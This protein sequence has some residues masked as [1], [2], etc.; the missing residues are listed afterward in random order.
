[1]GALTVRRLVIGRSVVNTNINSDT[2]FYLTNASTHRCK[3]KILPKDHKDQVNKLASY[4]PCMQQQDAFYVHLLTQRGDIP[5]CLDDPLPAIM[6]LVQL[7]AEGLE[8][9]LNCCAAA[10]V[11]SVCSSTSCDSSGG[12]SGSH[13]SQAILSLRLLRSGCVAVVNDVTFPG[14]LLG[15][16][17]G[18]DVPAEQLAGYVVN[19][20]VLSGFSLPEKFPREII[21]GD[22]GSGRRGA[23]LIVQWEPEDSC[24]EQ[25]YLRS[26]HRVNQELTVISARHPV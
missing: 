21:D 23:G 15:S 4:R 5:R 11:A 7:A 9:G 17:H 14:S 6:M 2:V 1:M 24:H 12:I 20:A 16:G 18:F 19:R 26:T 13:C 3:E 22:K 10:A 8:N 25:L